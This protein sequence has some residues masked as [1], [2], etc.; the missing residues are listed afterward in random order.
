[1][2]VKNGDSAVTS[3]LVSPDG[4]LLFTGNATGS[5]DIWRLSSLTQLTTIPPP[6]S[7]GVLLR[8]QN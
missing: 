2:Q 8:E 6:A 7:A 3:M 5:V 1:M 4:L